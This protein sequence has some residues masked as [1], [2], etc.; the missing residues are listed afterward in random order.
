MTTRIPHVEYRSECA[1][2]PWRVRHIHLRETLDT[3]F[4][5]ALH[6]L[7]E[8]QTT[9][10]ELVGA[11]ATLRFTRGDSTWTFRGEITRAVVRARNG[12][13]ALVRL[14][15]PLVRLDR[16]QHDRI[17]HVLTPLDIA[18]ELVAKSAR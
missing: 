18:R 15:S 2:L 6:L 12:T 17:L 16:D 1:N 14:D 4:D 5:A 9:T 8:A 10:A 3:P 11:D 13:T 7:T